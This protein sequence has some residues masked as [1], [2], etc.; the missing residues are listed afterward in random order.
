MGEILNDLFVKS[1]ESFDPNQVKFELNHTCNLDCVHCYLDHSKAEMLSLE[2]IEK[3][4]DRLLD[5]NGMQVSI[6]GGEPML[7]PDF[8]KIMQSATDHGFMIELLTNATKIDRDMADFLRAQR[9]RKVQISL[10]GDNAEVHDAITLRPGSFER[11]IAGIR[12]LRE[13]RLNVQLACSLL[14]GNYRRQRQIRRLAGEL[15][16]GVSMSYW[17]M[18][19]PANRERIARHGLTPAEVEEYLSTLYETE[20]FY[21]PQKARPE[22]LDQKICLAAVN[23]CRIMPGGDVIPCSRLVIPMGNV[24]QEDFQKIWQ[25]APMALKLRSLTRRDLKA[26]AQ[27]E[28]YN[29][30]LICP[31]LSWNHNSDLLSPADEVCY[32]VEADAKVRH[33][34][35]H[36]AEPFEAVRSDDID[37]TV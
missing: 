22:E 8:K 18:V 11:T 31:G 33:K 7:H 24:Y 5:L 14:K 9:I 27:C 4:F 34:L 10:Y 21:L 6:T 29:I 30:C 17:M 35:A 3:V 20:P 19:T 25:T 36:L 15:G 32:M 13:R 12:L 23:N 2:V 37:E 1:T 16:L 26:C 28:N